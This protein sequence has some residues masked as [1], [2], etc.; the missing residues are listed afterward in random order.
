MDVASSVNYNFNMFKI[1]ATG[2][3]KLFLGH[4]KSRQIYLGVGH[5]QGLFSSKSSEVTVFM[6]EAY[7]YSGTF[8]TLNIRLGQH[9][10]GIVLN[11][12]YYE[13]IQSTCVQLF[14]TS[15]V[16]I[17]KLFSFVWYKKSKLLHQVT[18]AGM[19]IEQAPGLL[20]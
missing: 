15:G 1:Q 17:L 9:A 12:S 11:H 2:V 10:M 4:L 8:P 14:K 19:F 7:P 16:D 6:V 13:T 3:S 18:V 20:F 5:S